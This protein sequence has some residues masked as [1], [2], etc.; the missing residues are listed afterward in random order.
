VKV[1][2]EI[3]I[4]WATAADD[5]DGDESDSSLYIRH[6][7]SKIFRCIQPC[8]YYSYPNSSTR[9]RRETKL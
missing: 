7:R 4:H 5:D 3:A 2:F 1:R 8:L 6:S 9:Q